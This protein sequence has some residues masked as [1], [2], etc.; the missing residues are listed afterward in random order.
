[1]QV[2]SRPERHA[3]FTRVYRVA[4]DLGGP[5]DDAA[6]ARMQEEA[7]RHLPLADLVDRVVITATRPDDDAVAAADG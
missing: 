3:L 5:G 1:V 4:L 6:L 2:E 7:R